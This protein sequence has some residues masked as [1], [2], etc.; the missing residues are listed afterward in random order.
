MTAARRLSG[1]A[2]DGD[3]GDEPA[4]RLL[5]L[6]REA[7]ALFDDLR[8]EA[9]ERARTARGLADGWHGKTPARAVLPS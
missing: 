7:R 2:M 6:D 4:P 9:M 3:P 5:R 1:V 8:H